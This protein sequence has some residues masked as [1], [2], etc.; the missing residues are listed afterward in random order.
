MTVNDEYRFWRYIRC[1]SRAGCAMLG[2]TADGAS[3][4]QVEA[5]ISFPNVLHVQ[6]RRQELSLK[7]V[8]FEYHG[9]ASEFMEPEISLVLSVPRH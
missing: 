1:D 4:P 2:A 6:V 5:E 7:R 3:Y 9:A 8:V